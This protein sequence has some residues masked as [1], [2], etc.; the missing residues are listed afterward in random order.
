GL[1]REHVTVVPGLGR[2]RRS[3]ERL[4]LPMT[5]LRLCRAVRGA[6]AL[7][8]T[9]LSTFPHCWYAGRVL[10]VPQVVHVYSSY[11][12]ARPYRKPLLARARHVVAPSA[13][14]LRL[15]GQ[16]IGGFAPGVRARVAYNGMDVARIVREAEAPLPVVLG[17]GRAHIGMVGNLDWR[18]NP[19]CL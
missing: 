13:D 2:W 3:S 8:S 12:E 7:Y 9:T 6:A 15:A 1:P 10:G 16:A 19:R 11:G 17:A 18:K 4:R 14:S 5:L